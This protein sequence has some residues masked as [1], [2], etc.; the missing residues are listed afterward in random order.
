[1]K[2]IL[3]IMFLVL[4]LFSAVG[5]AKEKPN[6]PA[7]ETTTWDRIPA[8]MVDDVLYITTGRESTAEGRCGTWDGEIT[9]ECSGSELPTENDQSN[10][11]TGYGYQR[12]EREGTVEVLVDGRWII[13]AT[14]EVKK[15]MTKELS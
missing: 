7:E 12:G 2:K 9:S 14:E 8:V 6:E 3:S 1:M 10:F 4:M 11:G 5:C 15:E 13:F